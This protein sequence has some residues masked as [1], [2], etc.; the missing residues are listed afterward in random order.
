MLH[1][2]FMFHYQ[3]HQNTCC[4]WKLAINITRQPNRLTN[5]HRSSRSDPFCLFRVL[6]LVYPWGNSP[7]MWG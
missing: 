3:L 5:R 1:K 4:N 7:M 6:P 2:I